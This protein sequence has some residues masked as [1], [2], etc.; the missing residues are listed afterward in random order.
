[1]T[2]RRARSV[3]AAS[4]LP[5]SCPHCAT[6]ARPVVISDPTQ[7]DYFRCRPCGMIWMRPRA[8]DGRTYIVARPLTPKTPPD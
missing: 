8:S 1:M 5:S 7:M 4:T 2:G 6:N 3:L